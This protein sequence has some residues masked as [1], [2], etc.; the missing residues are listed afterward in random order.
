MTM[1]S[2]QYYI[3]RKSVASLVQFYRSSMLTLDEARAIADDYLCEY[4]EHANYINEH[5]KEDSAN[6]ELSVPQK[7]PHTPLGT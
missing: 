7:D 4:P 6:T 1:N 5:L 2:Y 3:A